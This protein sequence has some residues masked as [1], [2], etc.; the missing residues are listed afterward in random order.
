LAQS[1]FPKDWAELVSGIGEEPLA[2]RRKSEIVLFT[3]RLVMWL[4]NSKHS[5]RR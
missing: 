1:S 2:K 3:F 5:W 4:K